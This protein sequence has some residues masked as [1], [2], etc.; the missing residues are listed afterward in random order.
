[1]AYLLKS[2]AAALPLLFAFG[3]LVPVIAQAMQALHI[4]APLGLSPLMFAAIIGGGWGLVAQVTGR[5]I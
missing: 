2:L 1:M 4:A 3:F 5:W